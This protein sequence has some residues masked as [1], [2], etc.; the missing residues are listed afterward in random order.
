MAGARDSAPDFAEGTQGASPD[1]LYS[2]FGRG[3]ELTVRV[4]YRVEI[5]AIEEGRRRSWKFRRIFR[6]IAVTLIMINALPLIHCMCVAVMNVS[7][8]CRCAAIGVNHAKDNDFVLLY[9]HCV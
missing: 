9:R 7:T 5:E 4:G 1:S 3:S 2:G 8:N 6:P